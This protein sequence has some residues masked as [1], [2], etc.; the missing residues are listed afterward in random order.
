MNP[1]YL[2]RVLVFA[3]MMLAAA[4]VPGQTGD[5]DDGGDQAAGG[6]P[7]AAAMQGSTGDLIGNLERSLDIIESG[8]DRGQLTSDEIDPIRQQLDFIADSALRARSQAMRRA[9]DESR[10]LSALGE[11]PR[12]ADPPETPRVE[13]ERKRREDAV[14]E[15]RGLVKSASV[16]LTRVDTLRTRLSRE[17]F[18]V[19]ARVLSQ[20]TETPLSP[21]L[22]SRAI[23]EIPDQ[24]SL[25]EDQ[26][27]EWWQNVEFNRTRFVTVMWWLVLLVVVMVV[28]LVT[29]NWLLHRYGPDHREESPS[30]TRRFRVMLAVGLGN[31]VLPLVSVAGLYVVLL[32]SAA[33]TAEV[34]HVVWI[35]MI[36]LSQFFLV[37]GLSAAALS[38]E[39][40]NW[41]ISR[42]TNDS[43]VRLYRGIRLYAIIVVALNL[44]SIPLIEPDESRTFSDLLVVDVTRDALHVLFGAVAAAL[45]AFAM[46][47]I[48]RPGNWRFISV[49]DDDQNVTVPPG[50]LVR[51]FFLVARTGLV[52]SVAAALIGF[53]NLGIFLAQRIVW[54][55]LLVGFAL[56]LRAFIAAICSQAAERESDTGSLV[57]DKLGYTGTGAERLMFWVMLAVDIVLSVAVIVFL[58]LIWGVPAGDIANTAGKLVSGVSIG[59]YTL[60]LIDIGMALGLFII[61]FFAVRLFQSFLSNR[62]LA[63]TVPDVGVR[64]ALTTG[65][66]YAGV[67]IAGFIAISSLGLELSQLALIFG[68]LSVGIGFGL[69]T[70]VNN[71]VSGLILLM[72]RPIKAGDWIVVGQHQGYVKKIN[73]VATEIQ[74]F[75]NAEVIVPNSQLVA[76]EVMNWTHKST[77]ARVIV[78]VGVS[79][80][81]DPQ[82]VR[83]V[84]LKCADD[85]DD[86]LRM[87]TPVVLFLDFG[88]SA[89]NFE[90]RFFI[91]QADYMLAI[92]S[93]MRF[94]IIAAFR[95]AGISIPYP[96]RD[97]HVKTSGG[98]V[99]MEQQA[100]GTTSDT[101]ETESRQGRQSKGEFEE[102]TDAD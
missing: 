9:E 42:F 69:Q 52:L 24:W 61:L 38:P 66:G 11:K 1:P 81:S 27:D 70:V 34:D 32:Q 75:D 68:A 99:A 98:D 56:L 45:I 39:Y 79:Y 95:E 94:A 53:V 16:V 40:P 28:V 46:F 10:L 57:L 44:A 97:V 86:V 63:Q 82:Q 5:R 4:Q 29:R 76:S 25:F 90:L 74:T 2:I 20:R 47:T 60:S 84:L 7:E 85:H 22:I 62:V 73:V 88:D 78:A 31:V 13:A 43:A 6:T 101:G 80:D 30:F 64:D 41:R 37:T 58:L 23:S 102:A 8:L 51:V 87:P 93:E 67:I 35:L 36:T 77:V 72:H 55:L 14:A 92:G 54:S 50:T 15:H 49:D 71:F 96:Q 12:N 18:G 33:L 100:P 65:V 48:L 19:L 21:T 59:E 89:L 26:I 83:E 91:R 3:S 17:E